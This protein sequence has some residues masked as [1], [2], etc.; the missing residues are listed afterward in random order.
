MIAIKEQIAELE[1]ELL[2]Q[3]RLL[4]MGGEREA[5]LLGKLEIV[6]H[7]LAVARGALKGA[8]SWSALR[9]VENIIHKP[10]L[11]GECVQIRLTG[12]KMCA[13]ALAQ[14]GEK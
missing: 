12:L 10:D 5:G 2:E 4:G 3:S 1:A 7:K 11:A 14:I 8:I 6:E 9:T 13:E